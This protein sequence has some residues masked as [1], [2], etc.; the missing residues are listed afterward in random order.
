MTDN[1]ECAVCYQPI[2]E[3]DWYVEVRRQGNPLHVRFAHHTC[4]PE[5]ADE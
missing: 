1:P 5:Q 4:P 2:Y 3:F